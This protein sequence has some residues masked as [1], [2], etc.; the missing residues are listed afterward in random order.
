MKGWYGD[1]QQHS[2]ASKGVRTSDCKANGGRVVIDWDKGY[3][4]EREILVLK[5]RMNRGE[6][7]D[8]HK[9]HEDGMDITP[10]QTKKGYDWLMNQW[11]TP[12]GMER[13]NNPF[14]YREEN[15]LDNFERFEITDFYNIG[16]IYHNYYVPV[17]TVY[18]KEGG[19]FEYILKGGE[20]SIIG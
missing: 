11:K 6:E 12:R 19:Y 15:I 10:E 16:N 9:I 1:R 14:G 5:A 3:I 4:T 2:L 8:L 18:A 7:V 20:V 13:K 17:Y